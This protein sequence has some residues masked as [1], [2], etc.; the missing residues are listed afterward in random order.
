MA[1]PNLQ[2]EVILSKNER[3]FDRE[4][5]DFDDKYLVRLE[6]HNRT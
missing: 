4:G 1:L 3:V 5:G 6:L 2:S